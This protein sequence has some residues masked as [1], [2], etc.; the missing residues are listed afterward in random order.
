MN[1]GDSDTSKGFKG[2]ITEATSQAPV[3][4]SH[5]QTQDTIMSISLVCGKDKHLA[6]TLFTSVFPDL[7]LPTFDNNA[8]E[9]EFIQDSM[10]CILE[11]N[12]DDELELI[13]DMQHFHS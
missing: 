1:K 7:T 9:I 5:R 2:F 4:L 11:R 10:R 8:K 6:K 3:L 12:K 13:T